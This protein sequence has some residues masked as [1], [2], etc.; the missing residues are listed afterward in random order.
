MANIRQLKDKNDEV[1]YPQTHT[2]AVIDNDGNTLENRLSNLATTEE[3]R[4]IFED[5]INS[6]NTNA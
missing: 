5:V 2:K 3:L 6:I 1:F 4:E